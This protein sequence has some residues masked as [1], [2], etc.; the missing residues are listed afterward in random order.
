MHYLL[1]LSLCSDQR[2]AQDLDAMTKAVG[3]VLRALIE[4]PLQI[5]YYGYLT[6][7]KV[8][9]YSPLLVVGYWLVAYLVNKLLMNPSASAVFRQEQLEGNFRFG[10]LRMRTFA[11]S[12][13]LYGGSNREREI[14]ETSFSVLMK[15]RLRLIK[16]ESCVTLSSNVFAYFAGVLNYAI[17]SLPIFQGWTLPESAGSAAQYVS[18]A[19]FQLIMFINGFT[20][21]N[22][23]SRDMSDFIGYTNRISQM[24]EVMKKL[25]NSEITQHLNRPDV[26]HGRR[27]SGDDGYDSGSMVHG[28][29][30]KIFD[31]EQD[32]FPPHLSIQVPSS[33]D[34]YPSPVLSQT[35]VPSFEAGAPSQKSPQE[36]ESVEFRNFSAYTP[37]G[38]PLIKNL[39]LRIPAGQCLLITGPSGS[40]KTSILRCLSGLW[41]SFE[42]EID[43]PSSVLFL[44]QRPYM[45]FGSLQDQLR[46]PLSTPDALLDPN[47]NGS[48]REPDHIDPTLLLSILKDVELD[49]LIRRPHAYGAM[50]AEAREAMRD[51]IEDRDG[52]SLLDES[53]KLL[54]HEPTDTRQKLLDIID[55]IE[56]SNLNWTEVLS[57]GEQQRI[58]LARVLYHRPRFAVLDEA[59][60]S[61]DEPMEEKF[62]GLCKKYNITAITVGH[63]SSLRQHHDRTLK[64]DRRGGWQVE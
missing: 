42:G 11:E 29:T 12:I 55:Q 1:F 44:P 7:E 20:T 14:A 63:K 62:Y 41:R 6:I 5:G 30:H 15:N 33:D 60:S 58:G 51:L 52:D 21:I 3:T 56:S 43:R 2:I 9:W 59:T 37:S 36:I 18:V 16:W 57:P 24:L 13:A 61:I 53:S 8:T 47:G 26:D 25:K 28:S 48:W 50:T 39:S 23:A 45:P 35:S 17:V 27:T 22:N 46:Y 4:A 10:H 19:S 34:S 31:V 40:G 38:Q 49:H 64:L 32:A 54:V